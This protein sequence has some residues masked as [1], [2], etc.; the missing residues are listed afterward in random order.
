MFTKNDATFVASF[1][2]ML[3]LASFS[4][5]SG[6]DSFF[7]ASLRVSARSLLRF[8]RLFAFLFC[9]TTSVSAQNSSSLDQSVRLGPDGFYGQSD[10]LLS[11]LSA[12][13]G[14]S[15]AYSTR[16]YIPS[17]VRIR[18]QHPT[19][20]QCLDAVFWRFPVRYVLASG[21]VI[22]SGDGLRMRTISGYC[23]DALTGEALIGA[24]VQDTLLHRVVA[25]NNAGYF[26]LSI[27]TGRV[28]VRASFVGY[29]PL[30]IN[31]GVHDDTVVVFNLMPRL[32]LAQVDVI[33]PVEP[34]V[35]ELRT[36]MTDL[37]KEQIESI[38]TLLGEADVIRALQQTPGVQS[39]SEGFGGMSVRGGSQDQ[40]MVFVDDAPIYNAN[41]LLGLFSV[42]NSEAVNKATLIKSGF[43]SRFGGRMSSV[44]DVHMRDGSFDRFRGFANIGLLASSATLEGPLVQNKVSCL[45]SARRTY[46]DMATGL[47]QRNSSDS[48]SYYFY[49]VFAKVSW[50]ARPADRL[51]ASFLYAYDKLSNATNRRTVDVTYAGNVSRRV[52]LSDENAS[53]WGSLMASLR[54][55]HT[56]SPN[57][58]SNAVAWFSRYKF[59]SNQQ[60]GSTTLSQTSN[61]YSNGIYDAGLRADF[62]AY[63]DWGSSSSHDLRFGALAIY[64][65]YR[66]LIVICS[67]LND[68]GSSTSE[69]RRDI[70]LRRAECH[71]YFEDDFRL[72]HFFAFSGIHLSVLSRDDR[73]PYVML[74]PR[75]LA[76]WN[77]DGPFLL[78][79]GFSLSS[80]FVYLHRMASI[81]TPA[82]IWMP[83]PSQ[84]SP[85]VCRQSSI[86]AS[87]DFGSSTRLSVEAYHKHFSRQLTYLSQSPY[88]LLASEAWSEACTSGSG[89][90]NGFEVFF[91]RRRGRLNGWAGYAWAVSRNKFP[92]IDDGHSFP[93][94]NDCR[95]SLQSFVSFAVSSR[96]DVSASWNFGSGYP[97]TLP[98]ERY[99][100]NVSGV[101]NSATYVVTPRRNAYRTPAS[102]QLN[103]GASIRYGHER[104][105]SVLSFGVYNVYARRNPMFV[106]WRQDADG[107]FS[108]KQFS[109]VAFPWPYVKYS[110]HF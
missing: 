94:D 109:L 25:S 103:I 83:V 74:E 70:R 53:N 1:F 64:K 105:G 95:H 13:S 65:C 12:Q 110:I 21:K 100:I 39:G 50:N 59:S 72:G 14:L 24:H 6:R 37:P 31:V 44:L 55:N 30:Q 2:F 33:A 107:D 76:G 96:F 42:F 48:Y 88:E 101:S 87:V 66:P 81:S 78:K 19:L 71:A 77:P 54:W 18:S 68:N 86:E 67:A 97:L 51:Q 99:S 106:Y 27:P 85:Q 8:C 63:P 29:A 28:P 108:L 26:C 92:D 84:M 5:V 16:V 73:R 58:Y 80:Q 40:N 93:S 91:H 52:T 57:L 9:L 61:G 90:A 7:D 79:A 89:Y 15:F 43:P 45:V 38:P 62:S 98:T 69:V 102:H 23:R 32:A 75:L 56:F 36:G 47:L 46:S 3:N 60:S 4:L 10:S 49:D 11:V 34:T 20:R 22:I 35:D 41:H 104:L 82:D 17:L